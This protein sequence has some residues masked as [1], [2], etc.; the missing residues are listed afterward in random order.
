MYHL[1]PPRSHTE[2]S[3][4]VDTEPTDF[5]P[6]EEIRIPYTLILFQK[7]TCGSGRDPGHQEA[8]PSSTLILMQQAPKKFPILSLLSMSSDATLTG[9]LP[10]GSS[11]EAQSLN[12]YP[13]VNPRK[14]STGRGPTFLHSFSPCLMSQRAHLKRAEQSNVIQNSPSVSRA[15][16]PNYNVSIF[17]RVLPINTHCLTLSVIVNIRQVSTR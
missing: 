13:A 14:S 3:A 12:S 6:T 10:W 2:P 9:F 8:P 11:Y 1:H 15:Q 7:H 4:A 17:Q 16:V 5:R